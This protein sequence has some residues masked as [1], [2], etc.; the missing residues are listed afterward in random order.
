MIAAEGVGL[1]YGKRRLFENVSI[2]FSSGNCY[3]LIGANGSG[4]STFLKI[5]SGEIESTAGQITMKSSARLSTLTQ[6]QFVYDEYFVLTTVIMGHQRLY[7]VIKEKDDLYAKPDFSDDDGIRVSELEGEFTEMD[8]WN[9]ESDAAK[10][11]S[12]LGIPE[13]LHDLNMKQLEASQKIRVL[14]AQALFGNPDI[15][16]LDEPTNQ[17]DME[18][19]MWLEEFL[20]DFENTAVVVSHERCIAFCV[21]SNPEIA[22]P[23]ALAALL[24]P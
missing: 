16:L 19:C 9:A 8:G 15:L 3:G 7:K 22:T 18:T 23:P 4:K 2:T 17:L 24:G 12:D 13:K 14:L 20:C 5:L 10:L 1:Q 21:I 6:D 11:L